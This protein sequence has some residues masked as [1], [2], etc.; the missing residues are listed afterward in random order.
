[1]QRQEGFKLEE[2]QTRPTMKQKVR[3]VLSSRG[4]GRTQ[5]ESSEKSTALAEEL[6]GEVVR[7]VYDRAS[8]ATH[9]HES[10]TEVERVKRFVDVVLFDL[11]ELG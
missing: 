7:A 5:R 8:L 1:M 9:V 4:R 2:R 10:R 6:S 11:L 3:F